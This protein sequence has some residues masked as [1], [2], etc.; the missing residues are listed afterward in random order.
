M[1]LVL[2]ES[3]ELLRGSVVDLAAEYPAWGE[4]GH[5]MTLNLTLLPLCEAEH[6]VFIY[7]NADSVR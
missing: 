2:L 6:E 3:S 7:E 1:I 4:D 5:G